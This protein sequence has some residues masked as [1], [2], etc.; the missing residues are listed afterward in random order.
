MNKVVTSIS[1]EERTD[2]QNASRYCKYNRMELSDEGVLQEMINT[3]EITPK[4][5]SYYWV[6]IT[7]YLQL[8]WRSVE[9]I[10]IPREFIY[11]IR[12]MLIH[13]NNNNYII[14]IIIIIVII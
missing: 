10:D 7:R 1:R 13:N 4:P 14:I 11:L 6:P 9:G 3:K 2:Y 12:Y 8:H 5:S